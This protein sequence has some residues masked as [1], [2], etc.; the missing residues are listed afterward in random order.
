MAA[1]GD[2]GVR[3][4]VWRGFA[5]CLRSYLCTPQAFINAQ[6]SE[7]RNDQKNNRND[8]EKL[9][10]NS[11][12]WWIFTSDEGWPT[13]FFPPPE[14]VL[15]RA[16]STNEDQQVDMINTSLSISVFIT[17]TDKTWYSPSSHGLSFPGLPPVGKMAGWK[18]W[19]ID[20]PIW[21]FWWPISYRA[22]WP[23]LCQ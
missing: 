10:L 17:K 4:W 14:L 1:C 12:I 13:L 9:H 23:K 22:G 15:R 19:I 3:S 11:M 2:P 20:Q 5:P 8:D 16:L 18:E 6:T 21:I 7:F